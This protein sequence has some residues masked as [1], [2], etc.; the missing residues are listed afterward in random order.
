MTPLADKIP[1]MTDADL[2]SLRVNAER[3]LTE[4]SATQ[5][6]TAQEILPLID[7]QLALNAAAPKAATPVKKRAPAKKLAPVTGHQTALP[8]KAA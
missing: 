2:K 7:A 1:T 3:L 8:T 4:G 5:V 6:T